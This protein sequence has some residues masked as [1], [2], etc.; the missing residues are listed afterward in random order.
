MERTEAESLGEILNRFLKVTQ[1]ENQAFG[2]R[3]ADIW[4]EVLGEEIT[5]ATSRIFLQKGYL[6]VELKSPSLKNDLMMKRSWIAQELNK[7]LGQ[8]V[9]K[10]VVIR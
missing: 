3:I 4:Q 2:E 1:I 7:K 9:V 5:K 10:Q 6:F 8:D